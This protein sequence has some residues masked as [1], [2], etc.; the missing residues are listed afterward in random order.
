[1]GSVIGSVVVGTGVLASLFWISRWIQWICHRESLVWLADEPVSPPKGGW[2]SL[3]VLFAARNEAGMVERAARSI[4]AEHYPDFHLIAV[5]DRSSDRT[6]AILDAIAA[7]DA[8]LQVVHVN[9]LPPGW[10]GKNHALHAGAENVSAEWLLFTDADVI[11]APETLRRGVALAVRERLDHLSAV[12]DVVTESEWERIFLAT[13]S[14]MFA[15]HAPPWK[16]SDPRKKAAA[17]VGAFNLVRAE[18]FRAVGGFQHLALSVDDDMRLGQVLK[19]AGYRTRLAMGHRAFAVRWQVGLRGMVL[20]LEKNFFAGIDFRLI[21]VVLAVPAMF[22]VGM[23]PHLG[24]LVGPWWTRAICAAG[25]GSI[26]ALLAQERG[27]S[28]IAWYHALLL[29]IGTAAC[30]LA[31][32]RSTWLTLRRRGVR[33]RD[34]FYPLNELR[35]HVRRRNAWT[36]EVWLSTR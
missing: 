2:P 5:D 14:L 23:G 34:H 33:W 26:A 16:V 11:L 3:A 6:G 29:P 12:P 13:F 7:E 21:T 25:L 30:A 8:R 28:G 4:L 15:V 10:L 17:G 24:L 20:G 9:D 22:A 31:L 32:I 36:R 1:M 19:F 18:A 27:Q 35:A